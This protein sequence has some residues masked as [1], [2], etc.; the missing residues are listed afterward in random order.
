MKKII[1]IFKEKFTIAIT[2]SIDFERKIINVYLLYCVFIYLFMGILFW[3]NKLN[4]NL[5]YFCLVMSFISI[6]INYLIKRFD[7][8]EYY[9]YILV[10]MVN[11]FT[12]PIFFFATDDI[13]NGAALYFSLGIV[14]TFFLIKSRFVYFILGCE[15]IYYAYIMQ[16]SWMNFGRLN[17]YRDYSMLGKGIS[18]SFLM[19]STIPLVII[20][21]MTSIYRKFHNE[22]IKS[23]SSI[24]EAQLNKSRFLANMTHEIRTPMNAII[25]MNELIQREELNPVAKELSDTIKSSSNQLLKVINNILEFSKL[26]SNKM[27]LFPERYDT[28]Q[29]IQGILDA[30]GAEYEEENTEFIVEI[31][32][33]IPS[34][35]F[36][37]AVRIKQIFM[38]LLFS[39]VHKLAHSRMY[40][41]IKS[42]MNE[43]TNTVALSCKISESGRGLSES[44]IESM[45]SS[46]TKYDSRAV[47]EYK[48]MALEFSICNEIINMMGGSL[49]IQSVESVGT[50]VSFDLINYVIEERPIVRIKNPLEYNVLVY[51]DDK[52]EQKQWTDILGTFQIN[53]MFVNGPN[54]FRNAIMD[55]KFSH[56]FVSSR[57]YPLLK[58]TI[59]SAGCYSETY[60][61]GS[62]KNVYSDFG[63]CRI[64]RRPISCINVSEALL[65]KWNV[66]DFK[67]TTSHE[68]TVYPEAK[69]LL[70][71]DS[72]VNL[73]VLSGILK[74]FQIEA[75]MVKSGKEALDKLSDKE[76]DLLIVEQR[77]PQM[78]G[79]EL[80]NTIR[81]LEANHNSNVPI[82]CATA[83]FGPDVGRELLELGFQDYLAKP[84]RRFYLE[85]ILKSFLPQELAVSVVTQDEQEDEK[86][87]EPKA[88]TLNPLG[89]D[90]DEGLDNVG[91]SKDA[92]STVLNAYY[93]EGLDKLKNVP[94]M[95]ESDM[96][97]YTT[98]VHALKSSSASIGAKGISVLF[99]DLEF[100]SRAGNKEFVESNTTNT[101]SLFEEVLDK[102]KQY[103][104]DNN[105]FDEHTNDDAVS[106]L[107]SLDEEKL[108]PDTVAKMQEAMQKVDLKTFEGL[109]GQID[110]KNYG[111]DINVLIL[112]IKEDYEMFD[113]KNVKESLIKLSELISA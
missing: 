102:V 25:G 48:G 30:V 82:V 10:L 27:E 1:D 22:V 110:Q 73:K 8:L 105:I 113:Y 51:L 9:S 56:I 106:D 49:N 94:I 78:D 66:N 91:G 98:N 92:F 42:D 43:A 4:V 34:Y 50:C 65:N 57:L 85:R 17:L 36:G 2:E 33:N 31:D 109:L 24:H 87:D 80:L 13:F 59:E 46:Y 14:L 93:Y 103:L 89:I 70:V 45:L 83:D 15:L 111:H 53:P 97:L 19:A 55:K 75:D 99:K 3:F 39:T 28:R 6:I 104:T 58:E 21:Y 95:Y 32:P 54:A 67:I 29:L 107:D 86:K 76:Y 37:D 26:D 71:D 47:S 96:S 16:F 38:Y 18:V 101:F 100:A 23:N 7:E 61:I 68:S 74:S 41:E 77:M 20:I 64:I 5:V 88:Q 108:D 40:L 112:S 11:F 63:K 60:V 79:T 62:H 52:S 84:V 81:G 35:R 69:V 12:F 72:I 44:E 90:F